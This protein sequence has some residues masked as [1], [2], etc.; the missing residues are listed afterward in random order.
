MIANERLRLELEELRGGGDRPDPRQ[1]VLEL[2]NRALRDELRAA[3]AELDLLREAV[4]RVIEELE[5][6]SL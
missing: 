3:R 4:E 1:H 2:E 5:K 6:A